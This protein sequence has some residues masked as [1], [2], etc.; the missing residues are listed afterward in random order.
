MGN[1]ALFLEDKGFIVKGSDSMFY[2]PISDILESSNI[3]LFREYDE[4]N[5]SWDPD[6]VVVGNVVSRGNV[7]AEYTLN[8]RLNFISLP[9]LIKRYMIEKKDSIVIS[10]THGKTTTSSMIAKLFHDQNYDPSFIIGGIPNGFSS[11]FRSGKGK[12]VVLEGDEYDTAFFDKRSKFLHYFPTHLIIN[13][14]EFDH[15]DIFNSVED[16]KRSFKHLVN[17]VPSNGII[18]ANGDDK[19]IVEVVENSH[20]KVVTFGFGEENHWVIRDLVHSQKH[21]SFDLYKNGDFKDSILVPF[22]GEYQVMNFT[23][24]YILAYYYGLDR[25]KTKTSLY[26]FKNVKRRMEIRGKINGATIIEDFAHHPTAIKSVLKSLRLGYPNKKIF[27]CFE[28]RSNTTV[29]NI[30]QESITEALSLA[31]SV[32]IGKLNRADLYKKEDRLDI[33]KILETLNS[34]EEKS[35][36]IENVDNIVSKLKLLLDEDYICVVMSN[37]SFDG[38]LNKLIDEKG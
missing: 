10:G 33:E 19:N 27:C 31:D 29:K 26:S 9:Q 8:N 12:M 34:E 24:S 11:G 6:L 15:S 3:E 37:G 28:P 30:F 18:V 36:H 16:I 2:P 17:I 20:S 25:D 22:S 32:I 23:A 35:W 38:L 21:T 1:F 13:N 5:L 4:K 14:I 7:E